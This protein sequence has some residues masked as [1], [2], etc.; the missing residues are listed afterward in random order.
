MGASLGSE[1]MGV[2]CRPD[3][4][5]MLFSALTT[6]SNYLSTQRRSVRV[7]LHDRHHMFYVHYVCGPAAK[8]VR[9]F[10]QTCLLAGPC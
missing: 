2:G 4:I 10:S 3:A 5:Q 7:A 6:I 8:V 9:S 1:K